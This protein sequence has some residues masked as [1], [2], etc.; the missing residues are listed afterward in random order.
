LGLIFL[1]LLI[2]DHVPRPMKRTI[3]QKAVAVRNPKITD[4]F[5][6][7]GWR[8]AAFKAVSIHDPTT[9][10]ARTIHMGKKHIQLPM[11]AKLLSGPHSPYP[12]S[13]TNPSPMTGMAAERHHKT[14]NLLFFISIIPPNVQGLRS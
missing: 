1:L 12:P 5:N 8:A 7:W 10:Q 2:H 9:G 11:V 3:H 14:I 4:M 6:G 13:R